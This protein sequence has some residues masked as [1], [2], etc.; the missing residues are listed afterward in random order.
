MTS[1]EIGCFVAVVDG[2]LRPIQLWVGAEYE[3]FRCW[4]RLTDKY[5][6]PL[7]KR[8]VVDIPAKQL[9]RLVPR[10]LVPC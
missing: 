6:P 10:D 4:N 8:M 9:D 5:P 7:S 2:R 1:C 3:Q